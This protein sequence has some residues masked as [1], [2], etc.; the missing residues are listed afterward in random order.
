MAAKS[1]VL[2]LVACAMCPGA[3][4]PAGCA[5]SQGLSAAEYVSSGAAFFERGDIAAAAFCFQLAAEHPDSAHPQVGAIAKSNLATALQNLGRDG[6]ALGAF[7]RAVKADPSDS[8]ALVGYGK[9]LLKD[10]QLAEAH[11]WLAKAVAVD[12]RDDKAVYAVGNV[13][14]NQGKFEEALKRYE[15]AVQLDS[16]NTAAHIQEAIVLSIL[17]QCTRAVPKAKRLVESEGTHAMNAQMHAALATVFSACDDSQ[18]LLDS[19]LSAITKDAG[20]IVD[21]A[22]ERHT[23]EFRAAS[24]LLE[25]Q[26]PSLALSYLLKALEAHDPHPARVQVPLSLP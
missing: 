18:L 12:P 7:A 24:L 20:A 19:Y 17:K 22:G 6:E 1:L 21:V 14:Q 10:G 3:C 15:R 26:E 4:E 23:N 13:L 9:A 11:R 25:R 2:A 8:E 5:K 16:A